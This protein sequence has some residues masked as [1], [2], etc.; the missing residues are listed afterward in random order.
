MSNALFISELSP[1]PYRVWLED[2]RGIF[3]NSARD[4]GI[5]TEQLAIEAELHITTVERFIADVNPTLYARNTTI[6]ALARVGLRL[7]RRHLQVEER[8]VVPLFTGN[9]RRKERDVP[10]WKRNQ[11][12]RRAR[13]AA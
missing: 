9:R 7:Y 13:R 12:N 4:L 3:R 11:L 5:S 10:I 1:L 8:T 6:R 2:F